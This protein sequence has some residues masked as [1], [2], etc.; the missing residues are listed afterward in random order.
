MPGI[1][2]PKKLRNEN[3]MT[4]IQQIMSV[5]T[6]RDILKS[7]VFSLVGL[8]LE[9]F[10]DL[11][12]FIL[13]NINTYP[14]VIKKDRNKLKLIKINLNFEIKE[15]REKNL[16]RH[17]AEELYYPKKFFMCIPVFGY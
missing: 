5:A 17:T 8:F 9:S 2:Y 12:D 15:E 3:T 4:G 16:G 13:I 14:I 1:W 6:I 7:I 10:S 11:V